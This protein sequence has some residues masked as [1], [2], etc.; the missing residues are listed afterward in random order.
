VKKSLLSGTV[1]I[2][3]LISCEN[4]FNNPDDEYIFKTDTGLEYKYSDFELYDSSTHILYFRTDHPEFYTEK[5]SSF[6]LFADGQEVY[7]G[8]FWPAYSSSLPYGPFIQSFYSFYQ[9]YSLRIG[10][11]SID[12]KPEDPRNDPRFISALKKRDL[13]H[14]GLF[15]SINSVAIKGSQLIFKFTVSNH[16]KTDLLIL[17]PE[18]TGPNLFHYFTNGLYLRKLTYEEVFSG[19][20]QAETPSPWNSWKTDWLSVLKSGDSRQFT[21]NYAIGSAIDPGK[22]IAMFQFPGLAFQVDRDQLYQDKKRIWLGDVQVTE[23]INLK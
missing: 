15:V 19:N 20:V 18:K 13:L 23:K 2:L 14:S 10:F 5:S 1:I 12:N 4:L 3:T 21:I 7:E 22:Y 11:I 6:K 8:V 16:D 17:D 9:D